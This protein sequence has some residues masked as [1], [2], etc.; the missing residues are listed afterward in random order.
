MALAPGT[1]VGPYEIVSTLGAGGMGEVYRA[2]D[3]KLNRD[4]AIKV[5]LAAVANDPDRLARF[6]REAQVLASLNHPNIAGIYGLED[7]AIVMELV[8]GPTLA[9][10]IAHGPVPVDEAIA[11]ARQIADALLAAHDAGVIHRDLKPANVKIRPDGTVKVL[12]F[13]L[14]KAMDPTAGSSANAMNSPTLS[15]HGTQMGMIIGTAAYMAPEQARG[16]AVDRRADIWAF[17]VV[18]FEMLTGKRAFD[19]DDISITLASVLKDD[20]NWTALPADVPTPMRRLLRRCLEKDPKR[21]LSSIGDAR[22]ELEDASAPPAEDRAVISAPVVAAAAP[23]SRPVVPWTVAA[24]AIVVAATAVAF[25]APWRAAVD[26]PKASFEVQTNSPGMGPSLSI[27]LSPDG[28]HLAARVIEQGISKLWVRPIERVTGTTLPGTDAA[29]YP[30]WS[31]DGR[32]IAFFAGG[33]LKKADILG[34]PPQTVADATDGRGGAWNRDG[35][36]LFAPG[37]TG[38]LFRIAA[39]GGQPLQVSELDQSRAETGHR[40]PRFLPDGVHFL[41]LV[42]STKPE[43][44]GIYVGSLNS[45]DTKFLVAGRSK[46]EFAP[47]DLLLFLRE[48][49]LMAQRLDLTR[50][51]LAG[52]PFQVAEQVGSNPGTGAAGM[53]VSENG[54]LAYRTGGSSGGRQLAWIDRSG[55]NEG[56]IGTPALFENPRLSPDGKRVA[57]FKPEGG[58]DIWVSDLERGNSTRFTFDPGS[59]NVPVWSPDGSRIAF[60][61]NRDGGVFNVYQKSSG[62]TGDDE[63]LLKTP[64][65]KLL[66]DWSA[67]GR[68]LLYQ[69]S[70]PKTKEDLWVLPLFGDRKPMRVLGTPF[71]EQNASFSPDGRWIAYESD[72]NGTRHAYVQSFPVSG[73]KWQISTTFGA[74]PRWRPDGKE[75]FFGADGPLMAVDLT[76]TVPGG[77]FKAGAPRE[78]F[79]GLLPLGPHNYD[80]TPGGRRFLLLAA[81]TLSAGGSPI[82]VVLNWMSGH[83]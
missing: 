8:E 36:I 42:F 68:Y 61:S 46:P 58:G 52:D 14:A 43:H 74:V 15:V 37:P 31:A 76:G 26:P 75:L 41:Y 24:L 53:T 78:L 23:V 79:Q 28:R 64:N 29:A 70:D 17:G 44:S 39:S 65:N 63:L 69:E 71:S 27:A 83:K 47:P 49:T 3:S 38:P 21:R 77:Q 10:R 18:L 56:I 33:K 67:D 45:K 81:P 51:E 82:V 2:R 11:I 50:L 25:W 72:E 55:K 19:G 59:D 4:V 80:V 7:N 5:L 48:S 40:F 13:G 32:Y 12:D 62:G 54:V 1:R 22:L 60:V 20:L 34:A 66:N 6:A 9:D 35:V 30:F 73:G 16:R 57:V